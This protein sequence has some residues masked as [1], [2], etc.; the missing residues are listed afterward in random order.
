MQKKILILPLLLLAGLFLFG[1][2]NQSLN[3]LT[4]NVVDE[5]GVPIDGATVNVYTNYTLSSNI[6]QLG[7]SLRW[8]NLSGN[9]DAG[10]KTG[11][12]GTVS[13]TLPQSKYAINAYKNNYFYNGAEVMLTSSQTIKIV[14]IKNKVLSEKLD[15]DYYDVTQSTAYAEKEQRWNFNPEIKLFKDTGEDDEQYF[16]DNQRALTLCEI[17]S[18]SITV[19]GEGHCNFLISTVVQG[20]GDLDFTADNGTDLMETTVTVIDIVATGSTSGYAKINLQNSDSNE[21]VELNTNGGSFGVRGAGAYAGKSLYLGLTA[22]SS[23]GSSGKF[24]LRESGNF[25]Y[26]PNGV[27]TGSQRLELGINEKGLYSIRIVRTDQ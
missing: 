15:N 22:I 21:L 2:T 12:D 23:D 27:D 7:E 9:L 11:A 1:C 18:N 6:N 24:T 25:Q 16:I 20:K 3:T 10:Q 14:L 19:S 4:I 26:L 5:A 17:T 13:F 8:A